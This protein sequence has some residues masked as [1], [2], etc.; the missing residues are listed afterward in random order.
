MTADHD[1]DGDDRVLEA[2]SW[3]AGRCFRDELASVL[4]WSL[5]RMRNAEEALDARLRNGVLTLNRAGARINFSLDSEV[6][7]Q[8]FH[9]SLADV[10]STR[11]PLTANEARRLL[12]LVHDETVRGRLGDSQ[13]ISTGG[14]RG[15]T[16]IDDQLLARGAV[17]Y[18]TDVG[19]PA[20]SQLRP[21]PDVMFALGLRPRGTMEQPLALSRIVGRDLR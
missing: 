2:A 19:L 6:L 9:Q 1:A 8:H 17:E 4:G 3:A 16:T 5:D 13:L 14:R 11:A 10:R 15:D 12:I 7:P 21:H 20:A 18:V